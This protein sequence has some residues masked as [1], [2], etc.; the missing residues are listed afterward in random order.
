MDLFNKN[1]LCLEDLEYLNELLKSNLPLKICFDIIKNSKNEKVIQKIINELDNGVPIDDVIINYLPKDIGEYIK[2]LLKN[3]TFQKSLELTLSFNKKAKENIDSL[4]KDLTYPL[5]LL[6]VSITALFL[7]DAYGLDSIINIMKGFVSNMKALQIFRVILRVFI[8]ILYITLLIILSFMLYLT[9]PK[10]ITLLYILICKYLRGNLVKTY[11]TEQFVSLFIIT[12]QQ[13]YHTKE[14]LRILK[15]LTNKPIISFM[16]FHIDDEL[17][18]G[19][20]L[21]EATSIKYFDPMFCK[22]INIA[23]YT[24][25]FTG[26]L[27]NYIELSRKRLKNKLSLITKIISASSYLFIGVMIVFVYQVLFIPMQAISSF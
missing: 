16:A 3:L 14:S 25:N 11:F 13:G 7:F 22:F 18:D 5:V 19:M 1:K 10:R 17:L 20:S 15:S 12:N 21:K 26:V 27:N 2:S 4:K 6:F 23:G 24:N 9:K 8:Y